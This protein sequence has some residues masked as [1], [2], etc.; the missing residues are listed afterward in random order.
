MAADTP[1][2]LV[3]GG[4][5]DH[6]CWDRLVPLLEGPVLAVDLPGRG[7]HPAPFDAVDLAACAEAV[8]ADVDDVG[9]DEIVLV[10][11]S[12]AGCSMPAIVGAL[13]ARVQRCVFVACTVP[14]DGRSALDTLD[15]EVQE[16]A[17]AAADLVEPVVMDGPGRARARRRPRRRPAGGCVERIVPEVPASSSSRSTYRLAGPMPRSVG[18]HDGRPILGPDK[19]LRFAANVGDCPIVDMA[20][21]HMC[22]V[23]QPEALAGILRSTMA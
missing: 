8:V 11:H 5:F 23:S 14:E 10:G 3:H 9:F 20:A 6:R 19:Q 7:R 2:V 1:I 15:P 18:A 4:G 13:G 16:L 22:M 17:R 12:L 21:G